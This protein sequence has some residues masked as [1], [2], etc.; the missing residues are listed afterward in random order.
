M[1]VKAHHRA[2]Y[3]ITLIDDYSRYGYVYLVC[4]R[5]KALDVFKCF[6]AEV[7]AQLEWKVKTLCT[8]RGCECFS[9]T[10]NEFYED[11]GIQLR[12]LQ[13]NGVAERR[14]HTLLDMV[15]SMMAYANLTISFWGEAMRCLR[16][17][18]F[19]TVCKTKVYLP[20]CMS[21]GLVKSRT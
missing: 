1:N 8:D 15:R 2:I 20:H 13:Q 16:Q 7:Q 18:I 17:P 10:F 5:Y 6:V 19:L 12:T 3:F 14:N 9:D 21:Y 11:K 4:H